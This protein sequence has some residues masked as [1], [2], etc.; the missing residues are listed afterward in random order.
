MVS[1]S[2]P[3][4]SPQNGTLE[5]R[6]EGET[7]WGHPGLVFS[8]TLIELSFWAL[9]SD[10]HSCRDGGMRRQPEPP[11]LSWREERQGQR[12]GTFLWYF[13]NES[14]LCKACRLFACP[15]IFMG[16]LLG[17]TEIFSIQKHI[18][19]IHTLPHLS[20]PVGLTVGEGVGQGLL[21]FYRHKNRNAEKWFA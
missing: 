2:Y 3:A 18:I 11:W 5:K 14:H 16:K 13:L 9:N 8:K 20:P 10:G 17:A 12:P 4:C 6:W 7:P 21:F 19:D 15:P 1:E